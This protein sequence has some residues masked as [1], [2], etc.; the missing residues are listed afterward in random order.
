M[1]TLRHST[2]IALA[3]A[4]FIPSGANAIFPFSSKPNPDSEIIKVKIERINLSEQ[5]RTDD[6]MIAFERR[7]L[8]FGAYKSEDY[9]AREGR[10]Y[11]IFW[12]TKDR[13]P[14]LVVR[15]EYIQAN[16][17]DKIHVKEV[18]VDKVKRR[19]VTKFNVIGEE[20]QENGN[21]LAWRATLVRGDEVVATYESYL[22]D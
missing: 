17:E 15:F 11:T 10:Y 1:L 19:N 8:L 3:L 22:W 2:L 16:T 9:Y 5:F 21:V 4:L 7:H 6:P 14:G 20:F 12:E 13:A 18:A